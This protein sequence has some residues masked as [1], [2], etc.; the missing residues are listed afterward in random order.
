MLASKRPFLTASVGVG[1]IY[2]NTYI[3]VVLFVVS[4][5]PS[6]SSCCRLYLARQKYDMSAAKTCVFLWTFASMGFVLTGNA[7]FIFI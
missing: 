1:Y 7:G 5:R 3:H 2:I 6:L 4:K